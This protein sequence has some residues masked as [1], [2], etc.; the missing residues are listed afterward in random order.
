MNEQIYKAAHAQHTYDQREAH[1]GHL[2]GFILRDIAR[3]DAAPREWRKAAV[4]IMLE[5][6]CAEVS[7]PELAELLREVKAHHEAKSEV[8]SI[9]E[10][11]IES[12]LDDHVSQ[13]QAGPFSAGFTTQSLYQDTI[14]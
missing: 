7:H 6:G 8:Q 9:V 1:L 2:P 5:K 3:N 14:V 12:P 4:E 11:A 13:K 10:S